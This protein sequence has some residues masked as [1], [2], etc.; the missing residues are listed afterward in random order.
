MPRYEEAVTESR[1]CETKQVACSRVE[2][3]FPV[4]R[5][6][7][8]DGDWSRLGMLLVRITLPHLAGCIVFWLRRMS[9]AVRPLQCTQL[10]D[11]LGTVYGG[12]SSKSAWLREAWEGDFGALLF[13]A[14]ERSP[15]LLLSAEHT[16]SRSYHHCGSPERVRGAAVHSQSGQVQYSLSQVIVLLSNRHHNSQRV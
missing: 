1:N 6:A 13:M 9:K 14:P 8:A 15:A 7:E 10:M 5:T 4:T 2:T 3:R 11:C 16:Y 12:A